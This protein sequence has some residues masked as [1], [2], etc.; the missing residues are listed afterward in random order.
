MKHVVIDSG[1]PGKRNGIYAFGGCD[2][3]NVLGCAPLIARI[4]RGICAIVYEGSLSESRSDLLLQTVQGLTP[5]RL[6]PI[7]RRLKSPEG[8]F[9]P[10]LF[11]PS[12]VVPVQNKGP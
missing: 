11:R 3:H 4:P 12:F 10:R 7:N 1:R 6:A 2:L 9:E 5:E 8:Y